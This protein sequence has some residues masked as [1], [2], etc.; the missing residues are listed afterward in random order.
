VG[1]SSGGEPMTVFALT[2]VIERAIKAQV[3]ALVLVKGEV[4]NFSLHRASGHFYSL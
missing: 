4:S 2:G 3:P 1:Q